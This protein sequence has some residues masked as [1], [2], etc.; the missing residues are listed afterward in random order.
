LVV[1]V[2]GHRERAFCLLL[3]NYILVEDVI[4]LA[5]LRQVFDVEARRSGQLLIDDLVTEIDAFVA[6]VYAGSGDQ[7]LDLP[8]RLAAETAEKLFVGVRGTCHSF[9]S[10]EYGSARVTSS[11]K[12]SASVLRDHPIDDSVLLRLLRA[13]EIVAFSISPHL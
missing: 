12:T 1:V 3:T 9:L 10:P 13:H 2:D 4:D 11:P 5:R 8:L 7:L 6:D